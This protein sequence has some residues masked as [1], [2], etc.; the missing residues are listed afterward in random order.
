LQDVA[1]ALVGTIDDEQ[2]K[3]QAIKDLSQKLE[4][5]VTKS[6]GK[7]ADITGI[8]GAA[9]AFT[10]P[11]T[12]GVSALIAGLI[13]AA[14]AMTA[15]LISASWSKKI[16]QNKTEIRQLMN[17]FCIDDE[18]LD[19][20]SDDIEKKYYAESDIFDEIKRL[21]AVAL[22]QAQDIPIPDLTKHLVLW[23][24]DKTAYKQSDASEIEMKR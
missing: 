2:Q 12:G 16:D 7:V 21:Y 6:L 19:M 20:I 22:S 9:A 1:I 10:A 11:A 4:R 18:T 17:L 5:D 3:A 23:V 8:L 14:G 15:N 24:N 13:A